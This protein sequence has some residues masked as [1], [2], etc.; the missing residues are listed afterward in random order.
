MRPGFFSQ[1]NEGRLLATGLLTELEAPSCTGRGNCV[2]EPE[3]EASAP[4]RPDINEALGGGPDAELVG[5]VVEGS[6]I[7]SIRFQALTPDCCHDGLLVWSRTTGRRVY[8]QVVA[9]ETCEEA[10]AGDRVGFQVATA[11]QLGELNLG[12]AS[13]SMSGCHR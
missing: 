7:R 11:V 9:G 10:L 1:F 2:I 8:Y 6:S 4:S 3:D 5:F 12:P 13:R